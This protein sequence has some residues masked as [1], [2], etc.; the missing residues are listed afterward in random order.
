MS[1]LHGTGF[2]R[3]TSNKYL[4]DVS[5]VARQD[6]LEL[7]EPVYDR[8]DRDNFLMER[9]RM[10]PPD[11]ET[12]GQ[13]SGQL[14][15]VSPADDLSWGARI[16]VLHQVDQGVEELPTQRASVCITFADDDTPLSVEAT[17]FH[18]IKDHD[19]FSLYTDI[20]GDR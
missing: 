20:L 6:A 12:L 10:A 8:L 15:T 16:P 3:L 7:P 19:G 4:A 17:G 14:V 5:G 1:H 2:T 11:R 9:V 13:F 18:R